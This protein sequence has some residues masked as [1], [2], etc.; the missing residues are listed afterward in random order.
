MLK[1]ASLNT[2]GLR[3]CDKCD[4]IFGFLQVWNYDVILLQETFWDDNLALYF[5]GK[6]DGDI[7]FSNFDNNRRGVAILV[8]NDIKH[9][10]KFVTKDT[11]GRFVHINYETGDE[12]VNIFNIYSPN[13]TRERSQFFN[14]VNNKIAEFENIIL[15]GDFNL[16]L[17]ALDRRPQANFVRDCSHDM[18]YELVTKHQLADVWRDRYPLRTVFSRSAIV[19]G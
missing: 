13:E 7:Y 16:A 15:G 1:I 11:E 18:L 17:T 14:F 19:L 8:K 3:N 10:F 5:T 2:N 6:W 4:K 9:K 12:I